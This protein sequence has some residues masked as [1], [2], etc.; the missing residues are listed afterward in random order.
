[1]KC[2]DVKPAAE[3]FIQISSVNEDDVWNWLAQ[4]DPLFTRDMPPTEAAIQLY[5][6]WIAKYMESHDTAKFQEKFAVKADASSSSGGN[7]TDL[8]VFKVIKR[9]AAK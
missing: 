3:A 5:S 4:V 8:L 2:T 9:R 7:V 1:M 6:H